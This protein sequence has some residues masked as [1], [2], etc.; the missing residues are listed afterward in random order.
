M[1]QT[2]HDSL[3]ACANLAR[4]LATALAPEELDRFRRES[5]WA[6]VRAE[7][8][9]TLANH[10]RLPFGN[11]TSSLS[12]INMQKPL[13]TCTLV[14][15]V[16]LLAACD[17]EPQVSDAE[18]LEEIGT[19]LGGPWPM[20]PDCPSALAPGIEVLSEMA[21]PNDPSDESL[22]G[23]NAHEE[24]QAEFDRAGGW[25]LA[26]DERDLVHGRVTHWR[27][28]YADWLANTET[29]V[30]GYS[31]VMRRQGIET[32]IIE[33]CQFQADTLAHRGRVVLMHVDALLD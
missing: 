19:H 25:Q 13:L 2:S 1:I 6:D 7:S 20:D 32:E 29:A 12:E 30:A 15:L 5:Q 3:L 31:D 23:Y 16:V 21:T 14:A 26:T 8:H 11:S 24:L 4:E 28:D 9:S 18:R 17:S 27:E 33:E 10:S 22:L